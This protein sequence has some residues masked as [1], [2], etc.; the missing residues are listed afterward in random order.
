LHLGELGEQV[1]N[2]FEGPVLNFEEPAL[3]SL[4]ASLRAAVLSDDSVKEL[5][6]WTQQGIR[7]QHDDASAALPFEL[8]LSVTPPDGK[9]HFFAME[10]GVTRALQT[11][12]S[13]RTRRSLVR[14]PRV[15]LVVDP[16]Q[17]L[18][19]ATEEAESLLY[20]LKARGADV[21][22]PLV[23]GAATRA[24]VA[25]ALEDADVFHYAGHASPQGLQLS[26][27]TLDAGVFKDVGTKCPLI[28]VLNACQSAVVAPARTD[29]QTLA[30]AILHSGA[31]CFVGTGW[32]VPDEVAARFGRRFL[33]EVI[34]AIPVG[35]AFARTLH[36][37]RHQDFSALHWFYYRLYGDPDFVCR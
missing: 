3:T 10:A 35:V 9:E 27:G 12:E 33:R 24:A 6:R 8:L 37:L 17:N 28:V 18:K 14:K 30:R 16:T 34:D 21:M 26:D 11:T 29:E 7:V 31:Q 1:R 23:G 20:D 5:E 4:Q 36:A 25:A 22:K 15:L 32:R 13:R 19:R 2:A